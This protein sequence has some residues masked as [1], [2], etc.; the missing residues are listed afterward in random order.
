MSID[1]E[2][3]RAFVR[4]AEVASFT[5]AAEQLGAPKARV[6][7]K[8]RSLEAS[9]GCQLF[10]R[11]TRSVR[12][13]PDGEQLLGR[14]RTL[15][16][17]ADELATL[18]A[19]ASALRGRVRLDMPVSLARD[20]VIP[21]LPELLQAHPLLELHVSTTDRLVDVVREGF[22]L[23]LRVGALADSE[24]VVT[25]LGAF[26][27]LNCASPAYLREHG[28][29]RRPA[30][31]DDHLVVH[32]AAGPG[33][34]GAEFEWQEGAR[35]RTRR[36]RCLISVNNTDAFRAACLAGLGIAQLPG[37][38][39]RGLLAR[40]EL[41]EILPRARQA[42]LPISLLHP[43]GRRVPR[44]VRAVH[45]WLAAL[46]RPYLDSPCAIGTRAAASV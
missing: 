14:A 13:S 8:V 10:H 9:L 19:G 45:D 16:G 20:L 31:L 23:V 26:E 33:P 28:T 30:D 39:V 5:R 32:Y 7:Q 11:T 42:P 4:V 34:G 3:L 22:D 35:T 15:L 38:G 43:H 1:L 44:R 40:G 25:R 24:L 18:F 6:S 2:A 27:M 36:M 41:V 37:Y 29:P 46:L 21:R 12:L 17:E